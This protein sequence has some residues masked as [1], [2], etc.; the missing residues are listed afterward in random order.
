M[1]ELVG[2]KLCGCLLPITYEEFF[3]LICHRVEVC[4]LDVS[5]GNCN[6]VRVWLE[7]KLYVFRPFNDQ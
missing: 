2:D 6:S 1:L 5:G 3:V 7:C 4:C